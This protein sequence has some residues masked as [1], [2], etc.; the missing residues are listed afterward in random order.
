MPKSPTYEELLQRILKLEK[1][2]A[3]LNENLKTLKARY[4]QLDLAMS[5][6]NE[7]IW[8]WDLKTDTVVF[9]DRYY[10]I[11]GYKPDEFPHTLE[12]FQKRVHKDDLEHVMQCTKAYIN[13]NSDRFVV[14][15]RF[16]HKNGSWLWILGQGKIVERNK[17]GKPTRFIGTHTDITDR[18]VA[19]Q[20]L[21]T[22]Q[23]KLQQAQYV[24]KMGDFT[25]DL[26]SGQIT[27]S[28]GMRRL[29]KYD[30]DEEID[31]RKVN[32]AIHHPEDR[33]RVESWLQESMAQGITKLPPNNYRLICKDGMVIHVL[34]EGEIYYENGKPVSV[35]GTCQDITSLKK[36][37]LALEENEKKYRTIVE[38]APLGILYFNTQGVIVDCN[39]AFVD[40]LGTSRE[41]LIGLDMYHDL[42]NQK[43]IAK[44]KKAMREGAAIYED[45]YTSVTGSN[46]AYVNVN[47]KA[48]QDQGGR[49]VAGIGIVEDITERMRVEMALRESEQN[50]QIKNEEYQAQN[51][52]LL[53]AKSVLEESK[54]LLQDITDNMFDLVS[55]ADMSGNMTFVN[56]AHELFGYKTEELIGM[57][58]LE[59]VHLKDRDMVQNRFKTFLKNQQNT[60]VEYRSQTKSGQ[61]YWLETIGKWLNKQTILFSTR[62]ITERKRAEEAIQRA[63]KLESIGT[64]AGGIAH[65]FNNLLTGIYGNVELAKMLSKAANIN[66]YLEKSLNTIDRAQN[67][68]G[69]LLTFAKGGAPIKRVEKLEPFL[70]ET[71]DFALSGSLV[72]CEFEVQDNLWHCHIDKHQIGQAI[73]NIVINAQQAMPDGGSLK[74]TAQNVVFKNTEHKDIQPGNYVKLVFQ[75]FGIGIPKE[76]LPR[77]FDPFFSTKATGHGIGLST[78]FSI[79]IRHG[80]AIDVESEPDKGTTFF[81]YLP[82]ANQAILKGEEQVITSHRGSGV[83]IVMDDEPVVRQNLKDLLEMFGYTVVTFEKGEHVIEFCVTELEH[84][85]DIAGMIFDLTIPGGLGGKEAMASI[86]DIGCDIPVFVASGYTDDPIMAKPDD[87]GFK[88]SLRKPFKIKDLIDLLNKHIA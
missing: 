18:K 19:E 81:V 56:K 2:E 34:T 76:Y 64:L 87:Y 73:D 53:E 6:K 5:V 75:D 57:N 48:I 20:D 27:W 32:S 80:G 71:V 36:T 29:L 66:R 12:E 22:N 28:E 47:F 49:T 1:R 84:K 3:K 4:E 31:F 55:L 16:K 59:L 38:T 82:A 23:F 65:D 15:F 44:I 46:T 10:T 77:I 63:S 26:N 30:P 24:A 42:T 7:G 35:F 69:Q 52:E 39:Q 86:R 45:W 79:I 14:E 70:R 50:L 40:I 41:A 68:T 54:Q 74:I 51:R 61:I 58:V 13:D 21:R 33:A 88:A 60:R 17:S 37:E 62:D 25:W 43:L 11:A 8:D 85:N 67:L 9:E 72:S 83:F 78:T